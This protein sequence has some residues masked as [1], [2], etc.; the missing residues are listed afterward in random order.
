LGSS[1]FVFIKFP[2]GGGSAG[3]PDPPRPRRPGGGWGGGGDSK[4]SRSPAEEPGGRRLIGREDPRRGR[5]GGEGKVGKGRRRRSCSPRRPS[6]CF[7]LGSPPPRAGGGCWAWGPGSYTPGQ[8]ATD[9]AGWPRRPR[10]WGPGRLRSAPPPLPAP[11]CV[12]AAGTPLPTPWES[13]AP[14]PGTRQ[15]SSPS[16]AS[17]HH[18]EATSPGPW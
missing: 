8:D 9:P 14:R 5:R 4:N 16:S 13:F 3:P 2:L 10:G 1:G 6:R 12:A 18:G 11:A 17:S 7:T 15:N